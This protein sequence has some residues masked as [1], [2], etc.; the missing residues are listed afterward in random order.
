MKLNKCS[1]C[2]RS[3]EGVMTE[4]N[5]LRKIVSSECPIGALDIVNSLRVEKWHMQ[6]R[7]VELEAEVERL[8][9]KLQEKDNLIEEIIEDE[10]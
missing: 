8:R 6:G 7:I 4:L 5:E 9:A 3:E 10:L 2:G 1:Y